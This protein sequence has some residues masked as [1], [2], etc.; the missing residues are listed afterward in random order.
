[1][2]FMICLLV[3]GK[4]SIPSPADGDGLSAA[5]VAVISPPPQIGCARLSGGY[6]DVAPRNAAQSD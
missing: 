4:G 1:M 5:R 3:R 6:S 2:R